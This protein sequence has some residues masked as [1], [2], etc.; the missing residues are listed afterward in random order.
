L[1]SKDEARRI[2]AN[3]AKLPVI[4]PARDDNVLPAFVACA[5]LFWTGLIEALNY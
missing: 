1:L 5:L 3:I 2:A 4:R